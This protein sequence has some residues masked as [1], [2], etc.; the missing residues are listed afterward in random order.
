MNAD[1]T[2]CTGCGEPFVSGSGPYIRTGFRGMYHKRCLP[3]GPAP[4]QYRAGLIAGLRECAELADQ[5]SEARL[6]EANAPIISGDV[7][8]D[9][10]VFVQSTA[11]ANAGYRLMDFAKSIRARIAALETEEGE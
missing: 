4:D 10:G 8:T 6:D 3:H 2:K 9:G 1:D 11:D 7:F 5:W